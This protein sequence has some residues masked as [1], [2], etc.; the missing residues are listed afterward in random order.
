[1]EAINHPE[2]ALRVCRP[3]TKITPAAQRILEIS[4]LNSYYSFMNA[5]VKALLPPEAEHRAQ[6]RNHATLLSFRVTGSF[7]A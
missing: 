5:R 4:F 3:Q 7:V 1:M 2:D 6:G